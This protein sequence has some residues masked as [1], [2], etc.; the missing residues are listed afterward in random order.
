MFFVAILIA[1]CWN[2]SGQSASSYTTTKTLQQTY[3]SV[4]AYV[5][6]VGSTQA[7][8]DLVGGT[9]KVIGKLTVP[10]NIKFRMR[11][12]FKFVGNTGSAVDTIVL[13]ALTERPTWQWID[14]S[15]IAIFASGITEIYATSF[16]FSTANS[17]ALNDLYF[18]RAVASMSVGSKLIIPDGTYS[19]QKLVFNPPS[20]SDTYSTES[21]LMS[22][23]RLI[24]TGTG[25]AVQIGD[26]SRISWRIK[27]D[28][29]HVERSDSAINWTDNTVGIKILNCYNGKFDVRHCYG[30]T[31]GIQFAGISTGCT[32][33]RLELGYVGNNRYGVSSFYSGGGGFSTENKI[34]GGDFQFTS[35]LGVGDQPNPSATPGAHIYLPGT[36]SY[37]DHFVFY[38]PSLQ[39]AATSFDSAALKAAYINTSRT[40][41]FSPRNEGFYNSTGGIFKYDTLSEYNLLI[42]EFLYWGSPDAN[43]LVKCIDL[44]AHNHFVVGGAFNSIGIGAGV[45]NGEDDGL[46]MHKTKIPTGSDVDNFIMYADEHP[47]NSSA[48]CPHWFTEDN[49]KIRLCEMPAT[50]DLKDLLDTLGLII[51][52]SATPLN[53]DG[54]TLT[55]TKSVVDTHTVKVMNTTSPSNIIKTDNNFTTKSLTV[56]DEATLSGTDKVT[57]GDF[58]S[59]VTGWTL[60]GTTTLTWAGGKANV[61]G[62]DTATTDRFSQTLSLTAGKRS[63]LS[64]EITNWGTGTAVIY[65]LLGNCKIGGGDVAIP[66]SGN[67]TYTAQV[68]YSTGSPVLDFR[69]YFGGTGTARNFTIDNISVKEINGGKLVVSDTA[70]S[71]S[72]S[73]GAFVI[74][75]G[76]G[77]AKDQYSG[78]YISFPDSTKGTI[79]HDKN[80]KGWRIKVAVDGSLSADSNGVSAK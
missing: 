74:S 48:V 25:T 16:G 53:L 22:Y 46:L 70:T 61:T 58:A 28:G 9:W 35:A 26:S 32:Y 51:N 45:A 4:N 56:A 72:P 7:E 75:G 64:F 52:G 20:S 29:L 33:N 55:T 44:G 5:A 69:V 68:E 10:A 14:S 78:G 80:G 31:Y 6:A 39:S 67:G 66:I 63:L 54:G 19:I 60:S 50:T 77:V 24:K 40:S 71:T 76:F 12:G 57:N 23:G 73:T 79:L 17:A 13:S 34:Y 37:T 42:S 21:Q 36:P 43:P 30:F 15:V 38:S 18:K 65:C 2:A 1:M 41:I 3:A 49:K 8:P 47:I 11:K 62:M 27:V 59:D